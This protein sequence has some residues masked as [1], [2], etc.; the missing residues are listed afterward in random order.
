MS[1]W[2][3]QVE[4]WFWPLVLLSPFL[5]GGAFL[6]YLAEIIFRSSSR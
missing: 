2:W 3:K 5:L 4:R 1:R 6:T